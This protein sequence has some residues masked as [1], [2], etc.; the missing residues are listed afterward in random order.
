M[1]RLGPEVGTH[2]YTINKHL[3]M[4][5]VRSTLPRRTC[6][7]YNLWTS[8][9]HSS[10]DTKRFQRFYWQ[11]KRIMLYICILC[12]L[13]LSVFKLLLGNGAGITN[14]TIRRLSK[15]GK[16]NAIERKKAHAT[17]ELQAVCEED[18]TLRG[19]VG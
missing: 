19:S 6:T 12:P 7:Q 3:F 9:R 5:I 13:V 16:K 11:K 17:S 4:F 15:R 2:E 14:K 18:T 1:R 10:K 8:G